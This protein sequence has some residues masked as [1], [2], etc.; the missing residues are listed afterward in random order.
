MNK[1]MLIM[2]QD[3][4]KRL[5]QNPDISSMDDLKAG[6][7]VE[8]EHTDLY[9]ALKKNVGDLGMTLDEFAEGIARAHIAEDKDYYKKLKIAGL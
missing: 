1:E 4:L 6:I 3:A 5:K 9:D 8:K 2:I 7:E